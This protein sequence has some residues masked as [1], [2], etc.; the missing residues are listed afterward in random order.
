VVLRKGGGRVGRRWF[1]AGGG[2]HGGTRARRPTPAA[3][4][5]GAM[6]SRER[7]CE[8]FGGGP[9]DEDEVRARLRRQLG[10]GRT[11]AA[12]AGERGAGVRR[13]VAQ[14]GP[15]PVCGA[16]QHSVHGPTSLRRYQGRMRSTTELP[17]SVR[18][19]DRRMTRGALHAGVH[20][21]ELPGCCLSISLAQIRNC[22]TPKIVN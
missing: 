6:A 16:S 13:R 15:R 1:R 9:R 7:H 20:G 12:C 11:A 4:D 14:E 18:R 2:A 5:R 22:I 3:A 21:R 10:R 17:R 8:A 19:R